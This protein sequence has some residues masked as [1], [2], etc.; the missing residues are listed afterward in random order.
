M[1][2]KDFK[3]FLKNLQSLSSKQRD[4]LE[5][6]IKEFSQDKAV[7]DLV[8][9][10]THSMECPHC[11]SAILQKWGIVSQ[12]QRYRCKACQKTFNRLT[13]TPF[14]R[15]RKKEKWLGVINSL[16]KKESVRQMSQ[17]LNVNHKTAFRWRHR[18]L[19]G[20]SGMQQAKLGGIV[21]ADETFFR[22]SEKGSRRLDR[23]PRKRGEEAKTRGINLEDFVTAW[24]ARDRKKS[25]IHQVS[26]HRDTYFVKQLLDERIEKDSILC[27]DGKLGYAVYAK[28]RKIQHVVLNQSKK[29][30]VKDTVYHIQNVNNYQ[31]RLKNWIDGF[32]GVATKYLD[33]YL[34]WFRLKSDVSEK[35]IS[36][37][38]SQF[39]KNAILNI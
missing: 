4:I 32:N 35:L 13:N 29:E 27:T 5:E 1:K 34:V 31:A 7:S 2:A 20:F 16:E 3:E 26:R 21:E 23:E 8:N 24:I 39:L 12:M 17:G 6:S 37:D 19:K 15:L 22:T 28:K 14:S 18:F 25:T 38:S 11:G 36:F 33:N 9:D 10:D 30:R